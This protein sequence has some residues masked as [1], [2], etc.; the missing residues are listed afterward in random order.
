MSNQKSSL[1]AAQKFNI[2]A[3]GGVF[4]SAMVSNSEKSS[5]DGHT[6]GATSA[7]YG[8]IRPLALPRD[9]AIRACHMARAQ[10]VLSWL[11]PVGIPEG[12]CLASAVPERALNW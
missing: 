5:I 8:E 11:V 10:G 7:R 2:Y 6:Y 1:E 9:E 3:G 12:V 4:L